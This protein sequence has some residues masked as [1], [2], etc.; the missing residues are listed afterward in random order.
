VKRIV[1]A[2]MTLLALVSPAM[3]ADQ[4]KPSADLVARGKMLVTFGGCH[5]CH[6]PKN[7]TPQG[8]VPD[9]TRQLSGHPSGQPPLPIDKKA[10]TPGY[11]ILMGPDLQTY[12]GPWGI[13]YPANLTPDDQTG[14][15]LWTE[16][17]FIKTIRTGK[18][19]GEGRPLL[20]P[21]FVENL[22]PLSDGDLKAIYAYLRSIPAIKNAVPQPV[23]PADVK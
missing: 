7:M 21:M 3:A 11:W 9:M 14:I 16:D 10:L 2:A 6:T 8:P 5:D 22:A 13:S 23:A 19:M 17:I 4:P 15:G 12:V 1:F 20:P 18:H